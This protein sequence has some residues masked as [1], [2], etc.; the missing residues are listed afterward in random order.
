[1][2]FLIAPIAIA[3]TNAALAAGL[4]SL[5]WT[6]GPLLANVAVYGG[7]SLA[8]SALARSLIPD[9][10]NQATPLS[11][12]NSPQSKVS[13]KQATPF[14]RIIRGTQ[15]FGGAVALYKAID[16]DGAKSKLVMQ[17]LYS[18]R[19]LSS[20]TGVN[21]NGNLLRFAG[22]SSFGSILTPI[23][24]VGQPD[25]PAHVW[26]CFQ[27][28]KV[29]Q[30]TNPL[31]RSLFP[32]LPIG[33]R[34][35][36]IANGC[37]AFEFGT[38][39]EDHTAL[40]G[41]VQIP[42]VE[43]EAQGCPVYDPR[44]PTQWLPRDPYDIYEWFAAQE[45]WK[46]T[47][48]AALH[49]ADQIWQPDGL[50]AG[51]EAIDWDKVAAA[52]NRADE[53]CATRDTASSGQYEHRYEIHGVQ[54]M[55][56]R[57]ADVF[58]GMLTASRAALIQGFDGKCWVSHD[59]PKKSVFTIRDHM[60][61]GDVLYRGVKAHRDLAN[62]STVQFVAPGRKYQSS[63]GPPVLRA[64]LILE[65]GEELALNVNLPYVASPSAA[66]RIAKADLLDVR[67]ERSWA[68]VLDLSALGIREDD[69][70]LIQSDICPHWNG[71]YIV[72]EWQMTLNLGG[73]SG[74]ALRLAGYEQDNSNNWDPSSDDQPFELTDTED[75]LDA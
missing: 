43:P 61:I 75:L 35:P 26:A 71:L 34:L 45:S 21:L 41:N 25:Y 32:D 6:I 1:M 57:S 30:P 22:A 16:G 62:K 11:S 52:A 23:G 64:D 40:Y 56:Q 50:A 60:L 36:G 67:I 28:G 20:I 47:A 9:T 13:V 58:D 12:L 42:E 59:G 8:S 2:P 72:D 44:D 31:L 15:R 69:C 70:V 24:V 54:G 46:Y 38:D 66:Q 39:F 17:Y 14:Q 29:D 74:F 4:G 49:K 19:K 63:E 51:H 3:I 5:A 37:F 33:W 65:D 18:R 68:G 7:L 27:D 73:E 48:N 10:P 55:D 53:A